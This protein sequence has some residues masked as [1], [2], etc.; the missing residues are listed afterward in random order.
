MQGFILLAVFLILLLT[1]DLCH[2]VLS[3]VN[4]MVLCCS[5][6]PLGKWIL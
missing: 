5:L 1:A 6:I 2:V 3:G 4:V